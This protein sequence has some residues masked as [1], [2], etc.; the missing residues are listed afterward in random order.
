LEFLKLIGWDP[1]W[2][3]RN[4]DGIVVAEPTKSGLRVLTV[5][6]VA[7]DAALRQW[8]GKQLR[9][10]QPAWVAM[11][12]PVVCSNENGS[13]PVDRLAQKIFRRFHAGPHP[14]NRRLCHR[15][16][17]MVDELR[18]AGV[19]P[20]WATQ[21]SPEPGWRAWLAEVFPHPA[22]VRW[23][24]LERTLKYKKGTV[25]HR[26]EEFARLQGLVQ[27][28]LASLFPEVD[29]GPVLPL[30]QADWSKPVE[31]QV[32][33]FLSLLVGYQHLR[34]AGQETEVLG[35]LDT[36]FLLVPRVASVLDPSRV[37]DFL[38]QGH[39]GG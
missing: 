17:R 18:R 27:E 37:R 39:F 33:A 25:A 19:R 36:G 24:N 20:G 23:G 6:C 22:L 3:E 32:D 28:V 21:P 1:A 34:S 9:S 2:G 15:I 10:R 38:R 31:D 35:D 14:A 4:P 11:D 7:G 30:L 12:G 16:V 13:R 26:R 8:M 29:P 5:E